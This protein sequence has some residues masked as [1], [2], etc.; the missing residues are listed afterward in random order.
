MSRSSFA[1]SAIPAAALLVGAIVGSPA[2]A[3]DDGPDIKFSGKTYFHYGYDLTDGADGA[4]AF[5]FDRFYF[6]TK[7]RLNDDLLVRLTTDIG[8]EKSYSVDVVDPTTG[9]TSS[10]AVPEDTKLKV[11]VKYAYLQ[12][13]TPV[14]GV[15]LRIGSA[16]TP[17][18]GYYDDFTGHR[19]VAKAM[20]DH[21]KRLHSA[22]LGLHVLGKHADG[23]VDWQLS[24]V[25]GE[26]YG[27]PEV[28]AGKTVQ[29]RVSVDPLASNED[30][31][32]PISGFISYS[33]VPDGDP[34]IQYAGSVG[35]KMEWARA[36]GEYY[37]ES[38]GDLSGSGIA[39][40]L[41]VG[42]LD[43]VN[44]IGRMDRY[45][46]D[47]SVDNDAQ[48]RIIGGVSHKF[49]KKVLAAATYERSTVESAPDT[50]VHGVFL[51]MQA[52]F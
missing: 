28:D 36:W 20:T 42:K 51:R 10:V 39:A 2:F 27:G 22:D 29:A 12:W 23:L 25:N 45:D 19:F 11:F 3:S 34:R 26:G 35:F 14:D 46:P 31:T 15:K 37:G 21:F 48:M 7:A 16:G 6:T 50:P 43:L 24:A 40:T 17:W 1:R 49:Y 33:G 47:T 8:R 18:I 41:M 32:L 5:D 13:K 52:G 38:Q 9:A 4:N 30:L 44:V